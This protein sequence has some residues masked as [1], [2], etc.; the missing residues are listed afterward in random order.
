ME[1]K[2]QLKFYDNDHTPLQDRPYQNEAVSFLVSKNGKGA[3]RAGTGAGKTYIALKT[4]RQIG[5]NRILILVPRYSALLAWEKALNKFSDIIPPSSIC[6]IQKF[7]K[8]KREQVYNN[9][10]IKVIVSLYQT[11]IRDKDLLINNNIDTDDKLNFD[12]IICDESQVIRNRQRETYKAVKVICNN[13]K[14]IFLSAT[15]QSKGAQDLWTTLNILSP[16]VFTSYWS[17]I[18]RYFVSED[19]QYGRDIIGIKKSKLS[20]LETRVSGFIHNISKKSMEGFVPKRLRQ[21]IYTE[22]EK[23]AKKVYKQLADEMMADLPNDGVLLSPNSL[24]KYLRL[25]QILCCPAM[26][27]PSLGLGSAISTVIEHA[28]ANDPHIVVFSDFPEAFK[29]W[30]PQLD[31]LR[32]PNFTIRGGMSSDNVSKTIADFEKYKNIKKYKGD[33]LVPS[34]LMCSI[35]FA[36]SF[37][38]LTPE[39]AYFIGW[40]WDQN[41][42]YQAEGRLTRGN[43][44][45]CNLFYVKHRNTIEDHIEDILNRKVDNSKVL[46]KD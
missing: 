4:I 1:E 6:I 12:F 13:R 29:Y 10:K 20:E 46:L 39:S 38:L 19:G 7:S 30:K 22:V 3:I 41:A 17:F 37:D 5:Y 43:K 27:H 25:R 32:I 2:I 8:V 45:Y 26:L 14:C 16:N 11:A 9:H 18:N 28:S 15:N 44:K 40:S 24:S 21:Y 36:E 34:I 35:P 23:S 42:N 33:N 31:K